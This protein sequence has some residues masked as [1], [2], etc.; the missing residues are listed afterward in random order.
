VTGTAE[1]RFADAAK[2]VD[3]KQNAPAEAPAAAGRNAQGQLN[4]APAVA[5]PRGPLAN[6]Q[7]INQQAPNPQAPNPQAAKQRA[8]NEQAA[9]EEKKTL[10]A[11]AAP[12]PPPS[13]AAPVAQAPPQLARA[14]PAVADARERQ[15]SAQPEAGLAESV[16]ITSSTAASGGAR[17]APPSGRRQAKAAELEGAKSKDEIA[18]PAPPGL[19]AFTATPTAFAEPGGRL[20]WRIAAGRRLESSSDGGNKWTSQYTA[21]GPLRAG[22]APAIDSAWAVGDGGLV[23]RFVVPGGWAEVSRPAAAALIAVSATGVQSARV[24]ADDGRVFETADGGA[25]WTPATP[26]GDPR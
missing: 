11:E 18:K 3:Q 2:S 19:A 20:Q 13:P 9:T 7:A 24:T 26:E 6:Q 10:Q 5:R 17:K 25:T 8:G 16:T 1:G 23:L 14:E 22:I 15:A 21:R 12:A 4:A